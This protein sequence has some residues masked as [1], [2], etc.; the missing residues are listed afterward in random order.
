MGVILVL[1]QMS[2]TI[3]VFSSLGKKKARMNSLH[4]VLVKD[5]IFVLKIKVHLNEYVILHTHMHSEC[6]CEC[7][8]IATR[9]LQCIYCIIKSMFSPS[10]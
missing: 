7:V 10:F 5:E 8:Y 6:S 4:F 2:L 9:T 3:K 1:S